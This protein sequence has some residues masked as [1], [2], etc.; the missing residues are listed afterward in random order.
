MIL[1]MKLR[2]WKKSLKLK[3]YEMN[4]LGEYHDLYVQNTLLLAKISENF[5]NMR[6]EIY[7]LDS[8]HFLSA[9]GLVWQPASKKSKVQLD[10]LTDVDMLLMV[11]KGI[12]GGICHSIYQYAKAS[13]KYLKD[14]D[15]NK[16]SSY[17]QN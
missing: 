4:K 14:N 9:T 17:L 5:Q 7:E 15:N 1:L 2:A 3:N 12:R 11:E 16:E 13:N 8:A 10:L 6:L